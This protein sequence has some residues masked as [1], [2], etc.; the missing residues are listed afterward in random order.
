[1]TQNVIM[2]GRAEHAAQDVGARIRSAR[3]ARGLNQME[4][5]EQA[6]IHRTVVARAESS[7]PC[8]T[9]TLRKIA[10]AL[11]TTLTCLP[12]PFL[13]SQPY[14]LDRLEDS[15]WVASNPSFIRRKGIPARK[16]LNDP[17]ER[18]RLGTLGLAN[19][20]VRV[21]NNDLPGGR[22]HAVVVESYRK[23]Q[24]PVSFPGQMFLYVLSGHIKITIGDDSME[25]GPGDTIS[26]WNDKPNLYETT[27]G[28][29]ATIL[30]VFVDMSDEEIAVRD[31]FN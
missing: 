16:T 9:L 31:E 5:A 26:Y 4:L 29:P 11:G 23:E 12:R 13:G 20:F 15:L 22:L 8:R 3:V 2:S 19:A 1:M 28:L 27:N 14:R 7:G 25:M 10:R 21:M 17:D 30:E 18:H 6:G 24:E